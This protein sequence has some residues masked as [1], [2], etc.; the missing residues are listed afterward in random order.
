M[1]DFSVSP[2]R[3]IITLAFTIA[4]C[5]VLSTKTLAGELGKAALSE[6]SIEVLGGRL[7]VRMPQGAKKEARLFDILSAPES[8]EHETRIA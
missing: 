7:T 3:R 6:K 1:D 2:F 8:E 5:C 4:C